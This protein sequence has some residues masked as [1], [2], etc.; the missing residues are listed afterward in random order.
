[1]KIGTP[2]CV[3]LISIRK[4]DGCVTIRNRDTMEQVR[5]RLKKPKRY[6]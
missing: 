4:A 2:L 6:I 5:I 3:T 1:M